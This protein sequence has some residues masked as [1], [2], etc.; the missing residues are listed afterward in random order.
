MTDDAVD[1]PKAPPELAALL[2]DPRLE[3]MEEAPSWLPHTRLNLMPANPPVAGE[4]PYLLFDEYTT[5][6]FGDVDWLNEPPGTNFVART[7]KGQGFRL[8]TETPRFKEHKKKPARRADA[9]RYSSWLIVSPQFADILRS[10]DPGAI[11]TLPIDWEFS[12]G[13]KL[14]GYQ[15]LDVTRRI[16]AYDYTRSEVWVTLKRGRKFISGLG[17]PRALKPGIDSAF[18]VFR[19]DYY[20]ADIL[21]SRPLARALSE[22]GMRGIR[23]EDPVSID[24]VEFG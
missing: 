12:D 18:H 13:Q 19:D 7:G 11:Q 3:G 8:L 17:H 2:Q 16:H 24:T 20:R 6:T 23:F 22:A 10:F 1:L 21:M 14:D 4:S 9:W 15:F 5:E